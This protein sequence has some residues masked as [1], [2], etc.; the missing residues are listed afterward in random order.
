MGAA[1]TG[2]EYSTMDLKRHSR[3]VFLNVAVAAAI[4]YPPVAAAN[5]PPLSM[6]EVRDQTTGCGYAVSDSGARDSNSDSA[7]PQRSAPDAHFLAGDP[8]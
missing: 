8:L 2:R 3:L 6:G 1:G 5:E 4:V 7:S